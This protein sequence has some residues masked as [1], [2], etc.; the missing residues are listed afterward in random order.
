MYIL[1]VVCITFFPTILEKIEHLSAQ[2]KSELWIREVVDNL[3]HE[4]MTRNRMIA[5]ELEDI[6]FQ[7]GQEISSPPSPPDVPEGQEM[8]TW[9]PPP[10]P[11]TSDGG[12]A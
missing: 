6:S 5:S 8:D 1:F 3:L 12:I 10:N 7:L 11:P 9:V 2:L 4:L